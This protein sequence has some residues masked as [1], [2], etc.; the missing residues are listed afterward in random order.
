MKESDG[1]KEL[2]HQLRSAKWRADKAEE[3]LRKRSRQEMASMGSKTSCILTAPPPPPQ[4]DEVFSNEIKAKY[5]V[6][7][8]VSFNSSK[9]DCVCRK[10]TLRKVGG[11]IKRKRECFEVPKIKLRKVARFPFS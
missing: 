9:S 7:N 10:E 3:A 1:I 8:I 4:A 11:E 5:G 2:E 6:Q